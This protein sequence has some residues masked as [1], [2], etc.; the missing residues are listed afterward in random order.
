[1]WCAGRCRVVQ[2]S[3]GTVSS[4]LKS[5][6]IHGRLPTGTVPALLALLLLAPAAARATGNDFLDETFIPRGLQRGEMGLEFGADLRHDNFERWQ[7]WFQPA[8]EFGPTSRL[9][10]EG[11]L[12]YV[13]R[14]K[15]LEFGGWRA[16]P[17][18]RITPE[19]GSPVQVALG[20]E[21]ESETRAAKHLATERT[22][23]PQLALS[24]EPVHALTV[25][26]NIGAAYLAENLP[27]KS[28]TVFIYALGLRYPERG[29]F[30]AGIELRHDPL[31]KETRVTPQVWFA[32]PDE[33]KLRAGMVVGAHSHPYRNI[34]RLIVEKEF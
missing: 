24:A 2:T 30:M 31:E 16:E 28:R 17:R 5:T 1:M 19:E 33:W 29:A 7:G 22:Y 11:A 20:L 25:A 14:G 23:R 3:G 32:L 6:T 13:N 15:G 12:M 18:F 27:I 8:L 4:I 26:G 9:T 34:A 21:A 10:L